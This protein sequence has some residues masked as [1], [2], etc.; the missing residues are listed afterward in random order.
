MAGASGDPAERVPSALWGIVTLM[1]GLAGAVLG[2]LWR[3]WPAWL[4]TAAPLLASL[5]TFYTH[6]A[7]A[8]PS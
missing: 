1:L 7:K 4:L 8:V 3:R 6:L 5:W 2:R